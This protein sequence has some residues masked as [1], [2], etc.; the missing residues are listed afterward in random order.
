MLSEYL[1]VIPAL[2]ACSAGGVIAWRACA[3]VSAKVRTPLRCVLIVGLFLAFPTVAVWLAQ[4]SNEGEYVCAACGRSKWMDSYFGVPIVS[5]DGSP[6]V[7]VG[8]DSDA[9]ARG[10]LRAS[11]EMDHDWIAVGG[12]G[13]GW[14]GLSCSIVWSGTW[15]RDLPLVEDRPLA[16]K[17]AAKLRSAQRREA[18]ESLRRYDSSSHDTR[19]ASEHFA[20]W[21]AEWKLAH[22]DWP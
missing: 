19:S 4:G 22:P 9:Y 16:E 18:C 5:R 14:G 7:G 17:C 15:F 12:H 21:R 2:V 11:P 6:D 8:P 10:F 1:P 13:I 20:T 3:W